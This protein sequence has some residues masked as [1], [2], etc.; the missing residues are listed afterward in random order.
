M[1]FNGGFLL[2]FAIVFGASMLMG[3]LIAMPFDTE[4]KDDADA[5]L[6]YRVDDITV[7]DGKT[8][9]TYTVFNH[10][11][12][13]GTIYGYYFT[14]EIPRPMAGKM[15]AYIYSPDNM[16]VKECPKNS[17]VKLTVVFDT[18]VKGTAGMFSAYH[19]IKAY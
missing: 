8:Y 13:D 12:A 16:V 19:H 1:K 18:A 3:M 2:L 6:S 4:A 7:D 17:A 11:Y 15:G 10:G 5:Y 9:V 14:Y